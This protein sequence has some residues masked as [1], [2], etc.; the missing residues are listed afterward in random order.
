MPQ[1]SL[2]SVLGIGVVAVTLGTLLSAAALSRAEEE[3]TCDSPYESGRAS[4][5][6]SAHMNQD[7]AI[8]TSFPTPLITTGREVS[9]VEEGVGEPARMGGYVDFDVTVF[10]GQSGSILTASSY[11]PGN[12]VRRPVSTEVD[13]FFAEVLECQRPGSRVVVTAEISDM[14][15][16]IE[17][18]EF[19]Q[20]ETTLVAVVDVHNTYPGGATGSTR[21]PQAGLPTITQA[22]TG[23]HG[24]SFPNAPILEGL[25]VSVL[26]QG[27]GVAIAP[28]DFVI[29]HFTGAVWNTRQIFTSSFER[30]VPLSLVMQD[31]TTSEGSPGV[32]PGILEALVGQTVGSQILVSIPPEL[33]YPAGAAPA[34][35]PDGS[36][37]VYVLDILGVSN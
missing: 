17:E 26:K 20:N 28:G 33:G 24:F 6:V 13:D 25:Q 14:F 22:P 4:S 12:P 2:T 7:G 29:A 27:D 1:L 37:L 23:E 10:I 11:V 19:L 8:E 9:V 34:G 36:T 3:R 30:G 35:V 15:G 32:I 21:L 5:L 18:D 31:L 16:E